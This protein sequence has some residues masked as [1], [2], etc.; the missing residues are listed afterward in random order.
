MISLTF[1]TFKEISTGG[2][3]LPTI[4]SSAVNAGV[5]AKRKK[6]KNFVHNSHNRQATLI[7]VDE[8]IIQ[9]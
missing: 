4:H 6:N 8:E 5:G 1:K 7:V 3:F 9:S 2:R